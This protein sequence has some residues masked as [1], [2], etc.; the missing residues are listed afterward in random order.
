MPAKNLV[1]EDS[2]T[3]QEIADRYHVSPDTVYARIH[4]GELRAHSFGRKLF[5]SKSALAEYLRS[6]EKVVPS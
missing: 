2:F 6:T 5:V 1:D 3:V 4:R